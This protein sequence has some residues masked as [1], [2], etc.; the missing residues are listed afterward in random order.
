MDRPPIDQGITWV[1]TEDLD[2]TCRFYGETLGLTEVHDQGLC[3]IFR[4]APT[5]FLGVCRVRPGRFVEP[6]GVVITFVTPAVDAWHARLTAAG[7][8]CF[9]ARDPNGYL[10]EFQ[11]FLDPGWQKA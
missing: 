9:F 11:T 8:Y 4:L 1:Y 10:V 3:R 5:A 2:G 7:V 6:K